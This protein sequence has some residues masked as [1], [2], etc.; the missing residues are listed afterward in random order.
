MLGH[1][2]EEKAEIMRKDNVLNVLLNELLTRY[3]AK[4]TIQCFSLKTLTY[5]IYIVG[6]SSLVK[7]FIRKAKIKCCLAF[8]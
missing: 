3:R 8:F 4:Y 7:S 5:K 1:S 6:H 2:I